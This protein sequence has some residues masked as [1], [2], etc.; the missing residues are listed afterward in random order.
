MEPSKE[1][2]PDKA[3]AHGA[4]I[5]AGILNRDGGAGKGDDNEYGVSS[6][7]VNNVVSKSLGVEL[8]DGSTAHIIESD[9]L[10]PV[11]TRD[12][13]FST[14]R[15]DQ[16][17]VEFPVLEGESEQ[18]QDNDEI[19]MVVLGEED[20]IPPRSPDEESLAVE[21]MYDEDGTLEVEAEDLL[22]GKRVD[23][24]FEGVGKHSEEDIQAMK[25]N[26]PSVG[27]KQ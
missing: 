19:G 13:G 25:A 12:D 21:F 26:T 20:G 8:H 5:Q 4:A 23:A 18:A 9:E 15:D 2:S 10:I 11:Q 1:V 14:I 24:K 22:S 7:S 3:V 16:T 17:V 27:A 6:A